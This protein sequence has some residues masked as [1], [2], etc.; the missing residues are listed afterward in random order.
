M[1]D[2]KLFKQI[3]QI[4]I[5]EYIYQVQTSK[6]RIAK[7]FHKNSGRGKVKKDIL[8]VPK[9]YK[10]VGYDLE[11][12]VIDANNNRIVANSVSVGKPKFIPINGQ[13]FYSQNGGKFTRSKVVNALH[14]YFKE[15]LV[16]LNFQPFE[17]NN[18]PIVIQMNWFAPYSHKTPDSTNMSF[19]Y[20]KTFE[21][22]LTNNGY[23]IDDEV[24]YVTSSFPIY[25]PV[26]S[27]DDRKLVFT[28]YQD[29]R[30]EVQ[31]FKLK[32]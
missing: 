14:E 30:A 21:D 4:T 22:T 9:K 7:Y 28:F 2:K 17:D 6:A 27:F 31:Q 5:P 25:S 11:G 8:D 10:A 29:M 23:I 20:L 1:L 16:K 32:I 19:A 26:D 18:Y 3:R 24:R 13:L 15:E 12:Y